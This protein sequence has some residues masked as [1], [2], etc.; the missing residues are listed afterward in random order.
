MLRASAL[1]WALF[2]FSTDGSGQTAGWDLD[3]AAASVVALQAEGAAG[4]EFGAGI[5][6]GHGPDSLLVLTVAH[7]VHADTGVAGGRVRA[8]LKVLPAKWLPAVTVLHLDR[9]A[10][11]AALRIAGL[12]ASGIDPCAVPVV[13]LNVETPVRRGHAVFA[14]G[15]PAGLPWKVPPVADQVSEAGPR[16]L[17]FQSAVIERGHSG[18]A[19]FNVF[20]DFVAMI[21]ADEPPYG[22][23]LRSGVLAR[24]LV[25]WGLDIGASVCPAG[26]A[27]APSGPAATGTAFRAWLTKASVTRQAFMTATNYQRPSAASLAVYDRDA[28][29]LETALASGRPSDDGR[30]ISPLQWTVMLG[31][32]DMLKHLLLKGVRLNDYDGH[33]VP[34]VTPGETEEAAGALQMA[35]RLDDAEAVRLLVKAGADIE[36]GAGM[37]GGPGTPLTVAAD[38]GALS[39]AKALIALGADVTGDRYGWDRDQPFPLRA[40]LRRGNLEMARVLRGAGAAL[41]SNVGFSPSARLLAIA[42]VE[43]PPES[44]RWLIAQGVDIEC[45]EA[46]CDS[47]LRQAVWANRVDNMQA[48]LRARANPTG[49]DFEPYLC[50]AVKMGHLE[51]LKVLLLAGAD[52]NKAGRDGTPL[53]MARRDENR[54]M[55][56]ALLA[57]GARR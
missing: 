39:A 12:R 46:G 3:A 52:P 4:L 19:L 53:A 5:V 48:L 22:V 45:P 44:L 2:A 34:G 8:R 20:G 42:A 55:I 16:E 21:R 24:S 36:H 50:L 49:H 13:R 37:S 28:A 33:R 35:A 10:D 56:E 38:H 41:K 1:A 15:N 14:V 43:A 27:P 7:V 6:V 57:H 32:K 23:A 17:R 18:G 26:R 51:A 47:P 31:R 40:A 9:R 54:P 11:V 29:A 30:G 25:D